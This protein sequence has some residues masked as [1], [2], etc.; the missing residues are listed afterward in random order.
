MVTGIKVLLAVT[1]F[2]AV[3]ILSLPAW[4]YQFMVGALV[5]GGAW[6]GRYPLW[7]LARYCPRIGYILGFICACAVVWLTLDWRAFFVVF[8][9]AVLGSIWIA[10]DERRKA[11]RERLEERRAMAALVRRELHLPVLPPPPQAPEND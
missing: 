5:A 3:P 10:W 2:A 4:E 11:R 1:P 9:M 8:P 7:A 6:A